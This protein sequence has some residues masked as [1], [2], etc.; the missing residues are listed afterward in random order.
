MAQAPAAPDQKQTL[1]LATTTSMQDSSLMDIILPGFEKA[2]DAKVQVIAVGSGVA[3]KMGEMAPSHTFQGDVC[4][5][6]GSLSYY[7]KVLTT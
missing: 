5:G 2:N 4:S 7:D 6:C 1:R 3:L